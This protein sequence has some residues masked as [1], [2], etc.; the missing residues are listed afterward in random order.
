MGP[1]PPSAP[2]FP[3]A[4]P[5]SFLWETPK[6]FNITNER[7]HELAFPVP[8]AYLSFFPIFI[9]TLSGRCYSQRRNLRFRDG[10]DLAR[11]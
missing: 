10:G 9:F 4:A 8:G 3:C 6:L 5:V 2:P 7:Q 1:N 11:G